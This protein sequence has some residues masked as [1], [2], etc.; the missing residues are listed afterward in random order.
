MRN[1]VAI[2]ITALASAG[3]HAATPLELHFNPRP[4]YQYMGAHGLDGLVGAPAA[5]ALAAARIPFEVKETPA[6][7]QLALLQ[8]NEVQACMVGWL[9]M[10][11]RDKMGKFSA[12]VSQDQRPAAV[13]RAG[14][15][16]MRNE[17]SLREIMSNKKYRLL[18]KEGFSYG[19]RI[20]A[21]IAHYQRDAATTTGETRQMLEM[22]RHQHADYFIVPQEE[23][24]EVI[25][26]SGYPASDFR[27]VYFSDVPNGYQ[28]H[29]WC[30]RAVPD[31]TMRRIDAALA[32]QR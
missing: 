25:A 22:V 8:A 21:A 20:D 30:T 2:A 5:K 27:Y 10:P 17:A 28:R 26:R 29:L 1:S 24:A 15:T 12:P 19:P 31:D 7:R 3:V 11:G 16:D 13:T 14:N 6:K 23:A 18:R 4:P 32:S 9:K